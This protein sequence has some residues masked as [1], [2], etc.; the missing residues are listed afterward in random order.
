MT[1]KKKTLLTIYFVIL[2]I[3][4]ASITAIMLIYANEPY[5][6]K[7]RMPLLI[8]IILIT[9]IFTAYSFLFFTI[10]YGRLK[11]YCYYLYYAVFGKKETAKVTLLNYNLSPRDNGGIDFYTINVLIWSDDKNDYV[12]R[13]VYVDAEFL[14]EDVKIN[15]IITITTNANYLVAYKKE[16]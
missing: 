14:I 2:A 16:N 1:K 12:E 10:S 5:G 4:V 13:T 11:K 3:A 8:A 6:T 9:V 15:D 7:L